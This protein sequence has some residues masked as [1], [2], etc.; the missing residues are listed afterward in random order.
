[1]MIAIYQEYIRD[2]FFLLREGAAEAQRDKVNHPE[3]AAYHEGREIAYVEV[4]LLMQSQADAFMIPREHVGLAD[5]DPLKDPLAPP[6]P[7]RRP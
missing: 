6:A 4:L 7:T 5:F 1:M 2:L 3:Q